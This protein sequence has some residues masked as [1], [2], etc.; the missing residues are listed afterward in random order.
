MKNQE[1]VFTSE[2]PKETAFFFRPT[3]DCGSYLM[4]DFRKT[5]WE[6]GLFRTLLSCAVSFGISLTL[7]KGLMNLFLIAASAFGSKPWLSVS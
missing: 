5:A 7:G 3:D 2:A 1:Y 6:L 4:R